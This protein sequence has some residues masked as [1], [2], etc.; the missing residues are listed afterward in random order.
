MYNARLWTDRCKNLEAKYCASDNPLHKL[1]AFKWI[2]FAR[3]VNV[4]WFV[5]SILVFCVNKV[6]IIYAIA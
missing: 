3:V 5:L 1:L 6:N 2:M 4:I